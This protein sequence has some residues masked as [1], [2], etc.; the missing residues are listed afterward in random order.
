MGP[1]TVQ[2]V[3][4]TFL[5]YA[6]AIDTTMLTT[7]SAIA[8][9]QSKPTERTLEKVKQF[10]DYAAS[11]PDA[12]LTY[13]PSN[14]VLAVHSD[15]SYLSEANARSRVGGH[16]FMSKDSEVPP[17]NGAVHTV[18]KIIKAVM[19]SAAEAELGGL[20]FNA[21]EAVPIRKTLE[22]LG[23]KQPRTPM[24][25]DNSTAMGV[26]SNK[27][28]PKRTKAMDMRF[29]WLRC[30]DAQGQFR[31]YWLPGAKNWADYWTKHHSAQ[32]HRDMRPEFLTNAAVVKALRQSLRNR[33][34]AA[35]A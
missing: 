8:E 13:S 15:A 33:M 14:M 9:T 21:R 28:Q 23:H 29:H 3:V 19:S 4:G 25:T 30:R 11:N 22:E 7:L 17:N 6:R 35:A 27:I 10:L 18:A 31:Y 16:Y 2:Q 26:V 24:Q 34:A 12:V 20:Y 5:F 1:E 32:H